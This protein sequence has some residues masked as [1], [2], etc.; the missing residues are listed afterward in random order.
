MAFK[1]N[2]VL[3]IYLLLLFSVYA[4]CEE[5]TGTL[6]GQFVR[7]SCSV[8]G[9]CIPSDG[10]GDTLCCIPT[11]TIIL[12]SVFIGV[13]IVAII[14]IIA[15]CAICRYNN[16]RKLRQRLDD[17]RRRQRERDLERQRRLMMD[18]FHT[19]GE[20]V[21]GTT[22]PPIYHDRQIDPSTPNPP[23]ESRGQTRSNHVPPPYP[24]TP[25]PAYF[26]RMGTSQENRLHINRVAN[27][28]Q[29]SRV[30]SRI[31]Q[32]R[33]TNSRMESRSDYSTG[34]IHSEVFSTPS[35]TTTIPP[36]R[37]SNSNSRY[38]INN[39]DGILAIDKLNSQQENHERTI[40]T[41]ED[42]EAQEKDDEIDN[43]DIVK[44]ESKMS[45]TYNLN[46]NDT[47]QISIRSNSRT[48]TKVQ[49]RMSTK[50][51]YP[52][53]ENET[54]MIPSDKRGRFIKSS[55]SVVSEDIGRGE[56]NSRMSSR[57]NHIR[58]VEPDENVNQLDFV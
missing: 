29:A 54:P 17:R 34:D 51:M 38:S 8:G 50:I 58:S 56:S 4:D 7:E 30:A 3:E 20:T 49:S 48:S 28:R 27:S 12:V 13:T 6:N 31:S 2:I 11:L 53:L 45:V 5:C 23:L 36:S 47:D 21:P 26:S 44:P 18:P 10:I 39:H 19:T 41:F 15:C 22:Q 40:I 42:L 33:A 35:V 37:S 43:I 52:I 57:R 55:M 24:N 14:T 46:Q 9:C 25:P 32:S 16:K 1:C